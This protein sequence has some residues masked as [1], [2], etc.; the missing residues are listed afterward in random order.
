VEG[1]PGS[2]GIC[3]GDSSGGPLIYYNENN[4]PFQIGILSFVAGECVTK[5]GPARAGHAFSWI[6]EVACGDWGSSTAYHRLCNG[7]TSCDDGNESLFQFVLVAADNNSGSDLSWNLRNKATGTV[8]FE[9]IGNQEIAYYERCLANDVDCY[10]LTMYDFGPSNPGFCCNGPNANGVCC[11][12]RNAG[13]AV[14]YGNAS[15]ANYDNPTWEG[16]SISL[17]LCLELPAQQVETPPDT[18]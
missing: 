6:Q 5:N 9:D 3:N 18:Q 15:Y 4:E 13:F 2:Q 7:Y 17:E 1:L 10:I 8:I 11:V 14:A 12:P 16:P